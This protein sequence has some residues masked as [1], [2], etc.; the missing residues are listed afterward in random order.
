MNRDAREHANQEKMNTS[1]RKIRE[2]LENANNEATKML[3]KRKKAIK[4]IE[5]LAVGDTVYIVS[6]D[7]HGTVLSLPDSNKDVFIQMGMMKVKVPVSELVFDDF[8]AKEKQEKQTVSHGFSSSARAGKSMNIKSEIDVRGQTVDEGIGNIDK[9]IDDAFLAGLSQVMIIH[10][11]GTGVLREAVQQ[12]LSGNPHV[13][14]YRYGKYG[15]GEMGV[16]VVEL[17]NR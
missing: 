7:Q 13:K 17:K 10:G 2:K 8:S 15:E 1:R 3:A 12:Y 5:K 9:Y 14:N 16:T 4:P 11:K 6:F